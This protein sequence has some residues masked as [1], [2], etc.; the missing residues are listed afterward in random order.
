MFNYDI[1]KDNII[2]LIA[3]LSLHMKLINISLHFFGFNL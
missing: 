2:G 3:K 1:A